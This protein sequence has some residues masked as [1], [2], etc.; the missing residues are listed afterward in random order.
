[1]N[2][3]PSVSEQSI[4]AQNRSPYTAYEGIMHGI[5]FPEMFQNHNMDLCGSR[6]GSGD[7]PSLYLSSGGPELYADWR[8]CAD[9]WWGA[10]SCGSR[11][12]A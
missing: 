10:P 4:L 3:K 11:M 12:G 6:Y 1:M 2:V 7:V 8:D 9:P 5:V